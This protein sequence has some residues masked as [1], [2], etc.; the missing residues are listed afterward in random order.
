MSLKTDAE[1]AVADLDVTAENNLLILRGEVNSE[2]VKARA[3]KIALKNPQVK[4]VA[5]HIEVK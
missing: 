2:A 1:L 3:E 5:N 4:K